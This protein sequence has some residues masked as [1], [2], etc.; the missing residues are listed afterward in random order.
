MFKAKGYFFD[1]FY[2]EYTGAGKGFSFCRVAFENRRQIDPAVGEKRT[3]RDPSKQRKQGEYRTG[4]LLSA[5]SASG[6]DQVTAYFVGRKPSFGK[7]F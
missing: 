2:P 6:K 5:E 4:R 3:R 7:T 1:Q